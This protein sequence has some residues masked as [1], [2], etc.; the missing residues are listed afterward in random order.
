LTNAPA[1]SDD[2]GT[3]EKS[4]RKRPEAPSLRASSFPEAPMS[5]MIADWLDRAEV[6]VRMKERSLYLAKVH[7][8]A[9]AP[10]PPTMAQ[11]AAAYDAIGRAVRI[12]EARDLAEFD[13][14]DWDSED[15]A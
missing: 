7:A 4:D 11:L 3:L 12:A 15:E 2:R 1:L 6:A 13:I 5:A 14:F 10:L 8:I 9:F